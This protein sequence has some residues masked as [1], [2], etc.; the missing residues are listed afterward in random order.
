[1]LVRL[2]DG[3]RLERYVPKGKLLTTEIDGLLQ[4]ETLTMDHLARANPYVLVLGIRS[5]SMPMLASSLVLVCLIGCGKSSG[6]SPAANGVVRLLAVTS[7]ASEV[8]QGQTGIT[9]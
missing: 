8:I 3:A 5:W 2:V 9:L 4:R 6:S 7:A 1:M